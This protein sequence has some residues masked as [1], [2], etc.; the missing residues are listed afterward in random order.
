[1]QSVTLTDFVADGTA[2]ELSRQTGGFPTA[3]LNKARHCD[4]TMDHSN[5]HLTLKGVS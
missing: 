2:A 5:N 4:F 1:M 3:P